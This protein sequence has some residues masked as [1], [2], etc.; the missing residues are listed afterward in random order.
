MTWPLFLKLLDTTSP[1]LAVIVFLFYWR[2]VKEE[3]SSLFIFLFLVIQLLLNG[4]AN[5]TR[6][7]GISNNIPV[8]HSNYLLSYLILSFY[9]LQVIPGR[10]KMIYTLLPLFY[11]SSMT[12]LLFFGSIY[13]F[14][15]AGF[16]MISI[17]SVTLCF[18][19][20]YDLLKKPVFEKITSQPSFWYTAGIFIFYMCNFMLFLT[21]EY[22]TEK[23]LLHAGRL[24]WLHNFMMFIFCIY[25]IIGVLCKPRHRKLSL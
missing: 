24:W 6:N 23:Q 8:Y 13:R 4:I 11:L 1:L 12:Y 25:C 19:Y 17:F 16:A 7:F 20:F 10:K 14:N 15:S 22:L 18:V 21:F 2:R 5:F 9:F 3:R